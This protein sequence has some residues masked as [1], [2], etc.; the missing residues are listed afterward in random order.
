MLYLSR[1][2][3]R[4]EK[5]YTDIVGSAVVEIASSRPT[6]TV[7]DLVVDPENG[8]LIAFVVDLRKNLVIAPIDVLSWG[9]TISINS[10]DSIVEGN[11]ILRVDAVQQRNIPIIHQ[12]VETKDGEYLGSVNDYAINTKDFSLRKIYVAKGFLGL[13]RYET[14][15]IPAK[16]IVEMLPDKIIVKDPHQEVREDEK[17]AV[18][19]LA[20]T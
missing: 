19:D 5:L 17:V 9:L 8:K 10:H 4:M 2:I 6:T 16:Q 12:K 11:E 7:K 1:N 20:A 15:I 14:R 18:K 3:I 13:I